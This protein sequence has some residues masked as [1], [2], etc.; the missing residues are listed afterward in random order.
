MNRITYKKGSLFSSSS[1]M[2]LQA[3]NALG[4]QGSG[5]ALEFLRRF[6]NACKQY[7]KICLSH[8][9]FKQRSKLVGKSVVVQDE[10]SGVEMIC[11]ITSHSYG[12][13]V[14]PPPLILES[15]QKAIEDLVSQLKIES[16]K[17]I[18]IHSNKFNSGLFRVPWAETEK[19]IESFLT[20]YPNLT[21]TVWDF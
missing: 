18:D 5:I 8:L 14:D 4:K 11:L 2:L 17:A 3:N 16:G 7:E 12:R 6:P 9:V 21:W 15:T 1:K 20:K 19:V 13:F 10:P